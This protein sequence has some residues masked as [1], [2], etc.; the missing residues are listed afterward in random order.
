[1]HH[2]AGGVVQLEPPRAPQVFTSS[3]LLLDPG[4]QD[5]RPGRLALAVGEA[6]LA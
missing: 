2:S 3:S 1:M 4:P 6:V 5:P